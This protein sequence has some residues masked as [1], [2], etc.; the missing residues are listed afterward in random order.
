VFPVAHDD[1]GARDTGHLTLLER[2]R[3]R[4]A[5]LADAADAGPGRPARHL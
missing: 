1:N 2:R 3:A 4:P 5:R